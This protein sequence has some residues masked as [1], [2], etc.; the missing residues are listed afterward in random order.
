MRALVPAKVG[1]TWVL[2]DAEIIREILGAQPWLPIP[3]ARAEM[4][5][6]IA[7]RG[8][9]IPVVDLA[10]PFGLERLGAG[11]AR[12]RTLIAD[13]ADSIVAVPMNAAREVHAFAASEL[14]PCSVTHLPYAIAEAE[15]AERVL[16]VIDLPRFVHEILG[17]AAPELS[18]RDDMGVHASLG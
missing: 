11:E 13:V 2:L 6:V 14:K 18:Q 9:A 10:A 3:G 12:P 8:R 7:W 17:G 4:P 1:Q 16:A 5:G 15:L